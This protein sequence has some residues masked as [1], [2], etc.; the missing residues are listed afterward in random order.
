MTEYM[1]LDQLAGVIGAAPDVLRRDSEQ[2]LT[3]AADGIAERMRRE[4]P[5]KTGA[6]RDSI[7]VT[8]EPG[9]RIIGPDVPY[10]DFVVLGTAPH[11]IEAKP[12]SVLAFAVGG[13]TVFAKY[14]NH[15]GTKPNPFVRRALESYIDDV[16]KQFAEAGAKAA[17]GG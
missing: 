4:A 15:P 10:A 14:V 1:T 17:V 11:R 8:T 5:V 12:G 7:K 3:V 16:A 2:I 13:E 9:K 6:L